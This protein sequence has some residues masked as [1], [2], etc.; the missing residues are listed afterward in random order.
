MFPFRA[1]SP[2]SEP[3]PAHIRVARTHRW[4]A[5][6]NGLLGLAALFAMALLGG[7][8]LWLP[9][10]LAGVF[11]GGICVAHAVVARGAFAGRPFAQTASLVIAVILLPAFPFGTAAGLYLIV[12]GLEPWTPGAGPDE[13]RPAP[14]SGRPPPI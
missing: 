7:F 6:V 11:F 13:A 12:H 14:G 1:A 9:M 3:Y 2:E 10:A 4:L 5:W 8:E